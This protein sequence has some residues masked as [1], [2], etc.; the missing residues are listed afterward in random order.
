MTF[1][2]ADGYDPVAEEYAGV[3]FGELAHKPFDRDL[4]DRFAQAVRGLGPVCDL[5]CGPGQ[6]ARY[7]HGRG[8]DAFGIDLSPANIAVAQRLNPGMH[9]EVGDMRAL[10][11]ADGTWGGIAAFYSVIH[12][13]RQQ[14]VETLKEFRRVLRPG[15]SLLLAFH[16]GDEVV[17]LDELWGKSVSLDFYFF[18][19]AEMEGYLRRVEFEI[20]DILERPPY[21]GV[22][23]PSQR[24]YIWARKASAAI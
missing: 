16:I 22:E 18:T 24:G 10:S 8:A 15:G 2:Q 17:H 12:I 4:L 14:V 11:A 20:L 1:P 23:H 3:Y 19:L 5:G 9:F 6:I 21:E 7:L 13:P